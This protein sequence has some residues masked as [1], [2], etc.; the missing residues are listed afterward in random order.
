MLFH[1]S[2]EPSEGN[3]DSYA[4]A[5]ATVGDLLDGCMCGDALS[6]YLFY[7]K[8]FVKTPIVVTPRVDDFAGRCD[9]LWAYYTGG[10]S[11]NLPNRLIAMPQRR[12][13]TASRRK[14]GF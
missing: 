10:Q 13:R 7:E 3:A 9:N 14:A 1:I 2:D 11:V 6:E 5:V 12:N 4:R 8:G